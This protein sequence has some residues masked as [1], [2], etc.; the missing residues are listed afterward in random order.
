MADGIDNGISGGNDRA[1]RI[2]KFL[3]EAPARATTLVL[4]A[5]DGESVL[6]TWDRSEWSDVLAQTI[7]LEMEAQHEQADV[8]DSY[9]WLIFTAGDG[10]VRATKRRRFNVRTR[11]MLQSGG[12]APPLAQQLDGTGPAANALMQNTLFRMVQLYSTNM[13]ALL[14]SANTMNQTA[15]AMN[16]NLSN[17]AIAAQ[18]EAADARAQLNEALQLIIEQQAEKPASEMTEAQRAWFDLATR[19]T[20]SAELQRLVEGVGVFL[21]AKFKGG[22]S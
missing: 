8:S 16:T 14:N 2:A 11:R 15:V 4:A 9:Y 13:Q 18:K 7:D 17:I 22:A 1:E 6:A 20:S 12:D 3:R 21:Q 10:D 19:A 5:E